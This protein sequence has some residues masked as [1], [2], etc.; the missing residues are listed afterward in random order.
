MKRVAKRERQEFKT[1]LKQLKDDMTLEK[2]Y[3]RHTGQKKTDT[4][5]NRTFADKFENYRLPDPQVVIPK[6]LACEET[7]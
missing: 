4:E 3:G 1:E 7:R 6:F 2:P 5:D